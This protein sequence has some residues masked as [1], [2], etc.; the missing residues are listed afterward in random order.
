MYRKKGL[1]LLICFAGSVTIVYGL[2]LLSTSTN[3]PKNVFLRLFPPH[4]VINS[5]QLD[6]GLSS[7]YIAGGTSKNFYLS[8]YEDPTHILVGDYTLSDTQRVSL[9]VPDTMILVNTTS[10]AVDSPYV[11]LV[12]GATSMILRGG[13]VD[14]RMEVVKSPRI[15]SFLAVPVSPSSFVLRT[16]DEKLKQNI[17]SRVSINSPDIQ[18]APHILEKQVDGF[19]CT[20]GMLH[21][22]HDLARMMY[23][24]FYRNEFICMDTALNILYKGHT[25]DTVSQAKIKVEEIQ[26]EKQF[27]MASPPLIVSKTSCVSGNWLLIHSALAANNEDIESFRG[28]SVIDVYSLKDGQYHFSFYLPDIHGEKVTSFRVFGNMLVAVQDRYLSVYKLNLP[29][30]VGI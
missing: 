26:S 30:G 9:S 4:A 2:Y 23:V 17:L 20:D 27:T 14:F 28:N 6:V 12:E 8:N 7:Y 18:H 13:L 3:S 21:Y 19:F 1:A 22:S 11:Y 24:Y 5:K 15:S 10:V 29:D 25:L 16:Y